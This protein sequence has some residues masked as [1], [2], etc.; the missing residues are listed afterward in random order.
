[1][2]KKKISLIIAV[3]LSINNAAFAGFFEAPIDTAAPVIQTAV[4]QLASLVRLPFTITANLISQEA[5][6]CEGFTEPS[7]DAKSRH[8]KDDKAKDSQKDFSFFS[9]ELK[10]NLKTDIGNK[11]ALTA[12]LDL[13]RGSGPL[14]ANFLFLWLGFKYIFL[15]TCLMALSK[16]NLPWELRK[17]CA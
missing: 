10:Q 16:S 9:N 8:S 17:L 7:K 13:F 5:P 3:C 14:R 12:S 2:R 6:L 11:P 4:F 15:F 1:M